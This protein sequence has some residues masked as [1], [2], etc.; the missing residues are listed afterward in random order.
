MVGGGVGGGRKTKERDR[1]SGKS[2]WR[3]KCHWNVFKFAY[4][5][6]FNALH[7]LWR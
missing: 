1:K 7:G 3:G 4:V 6:V 5:N 2:E